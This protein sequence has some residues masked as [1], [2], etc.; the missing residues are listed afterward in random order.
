VAEKLATEMQDAWL[1]FARHGD[2]SCASL[3]A[4]PGYTGARRATTLLGET[5]RVADA[6]FEEERRAWDGVPG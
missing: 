4:W 5:S 3:G 2:P 6:P 1:A